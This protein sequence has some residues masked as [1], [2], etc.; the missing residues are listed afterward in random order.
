[1]EILD[2]KVQIW[3]DSARFAKPSPAVYVFYNR[4]LDVIFIGSSQNVQKQFTLYLDTEFESCPCL[5][6]VYAYQK[7]FTEDPETESARLLADYKQTHGTVPA[8][9]SG[10]T[11]PG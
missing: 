4:K 2:V 11:G 8:C 3:I 10:D 5:Q 7:M 1:M 6:K 9:N